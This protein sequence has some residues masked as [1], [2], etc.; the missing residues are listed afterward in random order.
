MITHK[1]K[2][3]IAI[4][5]MDVVHILPIIIA[6]VFRITCVYFISG[7]AGSSAVSDLIELRCKESKYL[8][9]S[10]FR[11]VFSHIY[12][13]VESMNYALSDIL[14]VES[15]SLANQL[16]EG[17]RK[18]KL[19]FNGSLFVDIDRFFPSKNYSN[20]LNVV[21]YF[22]AI[23]EHKGIWNLVKAI[24]IVLRNSDD[25]RFVIGGD[26]PLLVDIKDYLKG[27][28]IIGSDRVDFVGSIRHEE[29]PSYLNEVKLLVLPSYGEGMPNILLEAMACG[30]PALATP[31]GGVPDL[32]LDGF[33]GFILKKNSPKAIAESIN[34]VL[35]NTKLEFISGNCRS[36]VEQE[37]T[38]T[39]AMKRYQLIID[40]AVHNK[41]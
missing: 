10:P 34:G 30:T 14:I 38:L 36:T 21:G 25:I 8:R 20:R 7:L 32:I 12:A 29:M 35:K 13:L 16:D 39:A 23:T 18:N 33:N 17:L 4:F 6:K 11:A 9:F 26:G 2:D 3:T 22:G 37:Y 5:P 19:V 24:P 1:R 40:S 28:N 41:R 15:P 27:S 31:V